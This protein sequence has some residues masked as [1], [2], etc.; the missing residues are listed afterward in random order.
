MVIEVEA[1]HPFR[2]AKAKQDYLQFY[3]QKGE[4][5]PAPFETQIVDTTF[6]QTFIRIQGLAD[7][8]P[9]VLLPGDSETSL[10]WLPVIA[11]FSQKFRT[12]AID[13]VYDNGCSIYSKAMARPEDFVVWLDEVFSALRLD[14]LNL[15]GYSYGGWQSALYALAYPNRVEKLV[16]LAPSATVLSPS[17]LLLARAILYSILPFRMITKNYFYWYGPDAV[18][19]D[20]TRSKVDEMI[21][22]DLLARRCF[23][24]RKFVF[25][26]RLTD[27]NWRALQ[28]PTLFLVGENDWTYSAQNAVKRLRWVAPK[29]TAKI[30]PGTD[31]YILLVNPDWVVRNTLQFLQMSGEPLQDRSLDQR[32]PDRHKEPHTSRLDWVG[33]PNESEEQQGS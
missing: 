17:L 12:Y 11:P 14:R 3:D 24:P 15:V 1:H 19:N 16:L 13:H 9:L 31:H 5:W 7:G 10:S 20:R 32:P 27:A 25:P 26:T 22:E 29:V 30:A 8:T 4:Q 23:K 2:S 21:E 33:H 18:K 6:G 28:M